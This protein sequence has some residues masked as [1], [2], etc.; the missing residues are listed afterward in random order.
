MRSQNTPSFILTTEELHRLLVLH[1]YFLNRSSPDNPKSIHDILDYLE[2]INLKTSRATLYRDLNERLPKLTGREV[3]HKKNK[4]INEISPCRWDAEVSDRDVEDEFCY[5]SGYYYNEDCWNTLNPF[6]I[7]MTEAQF[8]SIQRLKD[9]AENTK[10]QQLE[11]D[12]QTLSDFLVR[13]KA[14]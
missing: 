4:L 12:L 1:H 8:N 9:F 6:P 10:N 13:F 3:C 5:Q 11:S 14:D 7:P 2:H